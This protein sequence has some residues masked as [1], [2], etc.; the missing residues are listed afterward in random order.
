MS[1]DDILD[2]GDAERAR[3]HAE[4]QQREKMAADECLSLF[5]KAKVAIA[6]AFPAAEYG[7]VKWDQV[8]GPSLEPERSRTMRYGFRAT[9]ASGERLR[10]AVRG[11]VE[12]Q[13][14]RSLEVSGPTSASPLTILVTRVERDEVR[15]RERVLAQSEFTYDVTLTAQKYVVDGPTIERRVVDAVRRIA[16][17]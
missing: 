15:G 4:E 14:S 6:A 13:L 1:L 2:A 7:A 17:E 9:A 10:I 3:K 8:A 16:S 12:C 11:H 5:E